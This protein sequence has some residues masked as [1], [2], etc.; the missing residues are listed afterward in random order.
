MN[1]EQLI[2]SIESTHVQLS[3]QAV[4]QVN[5][6]QTI[7]NWLIGCY[8]VEFEQNGEDRAAYGKNPIPP[9]AQ[10]LKKMGMIGMGQRNLYLFKEFY[11]TYPQILQTVSAKFKNQI[12]QTVSNQLKESSEDSYQALMLPIETLINTLSFSHFIEL[13]RLNSDLKRR[14]YEIEAVKN[15]WKVR[16]LERAI[17]TLLFERTGLST[18][19]KGVISKIKDQKL[20]EPKDVVRNPYFLEFIGLEEKT[21]YSE[22]DLETAIINHLQTFLTELGR[23]FCFEARQKRITFGNTHYKID[24]IFYHRI[25]KCHVL[26]DLKLGKFDH[27]DSGQMLMYLNYFRKNE[28]TEGDNPPVGIILCADKDDSLVEYATAGLENELFISKYMLQLP[29]KQTL[30]KFIERE[31]ENQ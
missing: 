2:N 26:I 27:A 1:F 14:F 4:K 20:F 8:I 28:M 7:R 31:L 16:E 6:L 21:Q 19:K 5:N 29:D 30:L 9:L 10:R 22:T 25:L 23:G 18:D 3:T 13:L 17:N 24:L 12:S 11:I 15:A